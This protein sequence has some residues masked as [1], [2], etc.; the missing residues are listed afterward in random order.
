MSNEA[1]RVATGLRLGSNLCAPHICRCSSQ[2]DARGSH[3]LSCPRS[4]GR[5]MRHSLI[6]D[7]I[8]RGLGRANIAAVREPTGLVPASSLRPDGATLIP[9]TRGKCLAWDATTPDTLAASHLPSTSTRVGAA[10]HHSSQ[11]K[12]QKYSALSPSYHFVA[13]AVETMGPWNA[14]GRAFVQEL[15]RRTSVITGDPRETSFLFQRIS[16]A[17]QLGNA[18]S[19]T[20]SLPIRDGQDALDY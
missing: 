5:Q 18:A 3:G 14:E 2:V 15:G 19:F 1:I 17:V 13:V 11:L 4:A 20:G 7:I 12:D 16:V 8:H 9:W 6:N 10:A